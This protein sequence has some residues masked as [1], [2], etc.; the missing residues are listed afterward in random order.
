MQDLGVPG[1]IDL[2]NA[3]QMAGTASFNGE[4]HAFLWTPGQGIRDLGNLDG[5]PTNAL[6]LNEAGWVVGLANTN[7][8]A[9]RAFLWTPRDGMRNLGT[10]GDAGSS[11]ATDVNDAG[12]VVGYRATTSSKLHAFL[13]TE[14][15]GWKTSSRRREWRRLPP[16]TIAGRWSATGGSR[17]SSS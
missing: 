8:T 5:Q 3:G 11:I 15:D 1:V 13:W 2:N 6:S 17:H 9:T 16:L 4:D 12:Q 7:T 10:P 14:T